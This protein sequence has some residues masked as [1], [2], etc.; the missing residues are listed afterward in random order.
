[1]MILQRSTRAALAALCGVSLLSAAPAAAATAASNHSTGDYIV[2]F[3]AADIEQTAADLIGLHGGVPLAQFE[4]SLQ[5][6]A[7]RGWTDAIAD[8]VRADARVRDVQADQPIQLSA[9]QSGATWGLDRI[10][11]ISLPLDGAYRYSETAS[12]VHAYVLDTGIRASHNDFGDRVGVGYNTVNDQGSP[13]I[14]LNPYN[15]L[16]GAFASL[17]T[18]HATADTEDCHGH[19]THVAG[20]IGGQTWGVAKDVQ[21]HAVRVLGCNGSG[22]LISVV[23]GIE[24]VT[25]NHVK[26]AVANM[27][28]GAGANSIL[29]EA[30]RGSIAAGVHYAVAAG[31]DN[32]DACNYSPARVGGAIT[33]G[34]TRNDDRRAGFSNWGSCVDIFAPGQGIRSTWRSGDSSTRSLSGTSMATPHVAG[35]M[36]LYLAQNPLAL[37]QQVFNAVLAA[38]TSG[39][40]SNIGSG[41]P[42]LLLYTPALNN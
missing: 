35:A 36:A 22:S 13:V 40:L 29:D 7:V 31:N 6:M 2:L 3:N 11:Q 42:N 5:G 23:M 33:V 30:I 9:V 37:P 28:L 18:T 8:Q 26:P 41:S 1:M 27:S 24:W 39:Q 34:A 4:H 21:L 12:A 38:A 14:S 19:G 17:G 25:A 10:D 16:G 15:L 32:R 20:T